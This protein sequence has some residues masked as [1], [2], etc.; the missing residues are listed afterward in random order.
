MTGEKTELQIKEETWKAKEK[1]YL[2]IVKGLL[3]KLDSGL[4]M[5]SFADDEIMVIAKMEVNKVVEKIPP[6]IP[7]DEIKNDSNASTID[8][9]QSWLS[10]TYGKHPEMI[11]REG[12][13]N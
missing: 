3:S 8:N 5:D 9:T 4:K 2:V 11:A 6:T 7:K 13:T 12:F 1:N 10:T